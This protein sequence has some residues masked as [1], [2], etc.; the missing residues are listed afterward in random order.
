MDAQ[1][2]GRCAVFTWR[3][4]YP[5]V[6][7]FIGILGLLGVLVPL[8]R[9]LGKIGK[10]EKAAWTAIVFILVGF[11][12][13]SIYL[14]R[15]AHDR[16]QSAARA[17]QL[18]QFG[19]IAKGIDASI[20]TGQD[21]FDATMAKSDRI[22]GEVG[23]SIKTQT[24]GDSFAFITFTAE[25]AQ[26]FEMH[27]NNILAPAEQP[28][29]LVS[30]T[31]HG[32]YPLRGTHAI[33]MDDER[34]MAAMQEYNTHPSGDWI[35]AIN[36]ADTEYQ[37]PYLRPQSAEAPQGE[38]D[39]IGIYPMPQADSKRVTIAFAAPNGYWNEVLRLG[40][41]KGVWHQCLSVVGPT[42]KQ[43]TNP[44]IYCDSGW[45]EGRAMAERDWADLQTRSPH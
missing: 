22:I 39:V 20:A 29:F 42:V 38:V 10:A 9:D 13:R 30:V 26:T 21:H 28:Y 7:V 43:T 18:A 3:E 44:F 19:R 24:G 12:I 15:D 8:L 41:V 17:E 23:N 35:K 25:P 5:P 36:S 37:M 34:R 6:G 14:D 45:P 1:I 32:R 4:W 2:A 33:L 31:S 11:E 27:W 40:R 16:E